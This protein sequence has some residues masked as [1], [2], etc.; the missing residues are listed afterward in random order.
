M[1][2]LV[3]AKKMGAGQQL[4]ELFQGFGGDENSNAFLGNVL[5]AI[6]ATAVSGANDWGFDETVVMTIKLSKCFFLKGQIARLKGSYNLCIFELF[7]VICCLLKIRKKWEIT[8]FRLVILGF[9]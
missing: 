1:W 2:D 3:G 6:G 9:V 8:K 5:Q 4:L 7:Y